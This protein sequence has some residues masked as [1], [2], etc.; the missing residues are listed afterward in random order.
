MNTRDGGGPFKLEQSDLFES[1][2]HLVEICDILCVATAGKWVWSPHEGV[3]IVSGC[4]HCKW[5]WSL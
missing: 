3:V 4:S 1:E 5:V 2:A